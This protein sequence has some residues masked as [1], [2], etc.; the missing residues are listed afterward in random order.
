MAEN[1]AN[2]VILSATGLHATVGA[3]TLLDNQE[4]LLREGERTGLVG[5]NGAGKST[6][7]RILAGQEHFYSGRID[8]R[9]GV[10]TVFL[11]QEVKLNE[12]ATIRENILEGAASTLELIQRYESHSGGSAEALEREITARDG[13]NLET[14]LAELATALEVPAMDRLAGELSGGE[15]RR[16]AICR[17]LIDLPELLLLDEPTN[18]LD[19]R[20]IEW[21]EGYLRRMRGTVFCIT[22]DRY[23]LDSICTRIVELDNA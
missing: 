16:V 4:L 12:G 22:H 7:L 15:K 14:R 5:R 8:L 13:W 3:R 6:L 18:H 11:P 17:A 10:R 2:P 1:L 9:P 20:T 23:F 19:T 21:L